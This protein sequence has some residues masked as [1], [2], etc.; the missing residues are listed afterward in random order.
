MLRIS[1]ERSRETDCRL[2]GS[3]LFNQQSA[4]ENRQFRLHLSPF[5]NP[6]IGRLDFNA[7]SAGTDDGFDE[8]SIRI[9]VSAIDEFHERL[10]PVGSLVVNA[11]KVQRTE[12]IVHRANHEEPGEPAV[13]L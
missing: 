7:L 3:P 12:R 13:E 2:R 9:L 1:P 8:L 5:S 4:I 11:G 10:T 6:A